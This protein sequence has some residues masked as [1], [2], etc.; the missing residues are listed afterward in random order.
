VRF[1]FLVLVAS[2]IAITTASALEVSVEYPKYVVENTTFLSKVVITNNATNDSRGFSILI[3]I[4]AS[5]NIA[6]WSVTNLTN[7]Q[8]VTF[9]Q[10]PQDLWQPN[11]KAYSIIFETPPSYS[12]NNPIKSN[13]TVIL[14]LNISVQH[15]GTYNVYYDWFT[16]E[17]A[18]FGNL[19]SNITVLQAS[20]LLPDLV[21]TSLSVDPSSPTEDQIVK[22]TAEVS[23][24][25]LSNT[26]NFTVAVLVDNK[27]IYTKNTSLKSS[28]STTLQTTWKVV[29][30][31]H[32]I[33]VVVDYYDDVSEISETNNNK[34]ISINVEKVTSYGGGGGGGYVVSPKPTQTPTTM[35]AQ[36]T[37]TT[38]T[39]T[40]PIPATVTPVKPTTPAQTPIPTP[41]QTKEEQQSKI[42][43]FTAILTVMA[44][45][46]LLTA[47]RKIK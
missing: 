44:L 19:T 11:C 29:S 15:P 43:G 30:G 24:V 20:Q 26:T 17:P 34:T 23:N 46:I 38:P 27:I 28:D 40:T 21:V 32:T 1:V 7:P 13:S 33:T 25:G 12:E 16:V 3:N 41:T 39:V 14:E 6:N 2:L 4:P 47:R 36:A 31:K 42:P 45:L 18:E 8:N 5:W 37:T 9:T 35:P 22:I 10:A